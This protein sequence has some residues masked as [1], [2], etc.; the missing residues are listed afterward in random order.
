VCECGIVSNHY[1]KNKKIGYHRGVAL[2]T[3]E[4]LPPTTLSPHRIAYATQVEQASSNFVLRWASL[5]W[6]HYGKQEQ[7]RGFPGRKETT[8]QPNTR[9][10]ISWCLLAFL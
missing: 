6:L 2:T 1:S 8:T 4:P 3:A 5:D 10:A 7:M 9:N